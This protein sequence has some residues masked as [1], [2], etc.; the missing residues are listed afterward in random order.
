MNKKLLAIAV[1]AVVAMPA[2]A[3]ADVTVYGR[4]HVSVDM[5]DDGADYNE[6]NMSSNSSRLGF[7]AEKEAGNITGIVQIE[8]QVD[9]DDGAAFVSA[10]DTFVGLKGGLGMVRLGQFD[11]PFKAARGPANLFGDQVGDL[12]NLTRI[13]G[14]S[15][16]IANGFRARFDER[17]PNTIHFQTKDFDGLGFNIAYSI[18]D[19]ATEDKVA[20]EKD[21]ALS[22]SVTYKKDAL[23][24]ALAYETYDEDHNRGERNGARIAA[25]YSLT[26]ELKL[27]GF[28]QTVDYKAGTAV[29]IDALTSDVFGAGAEYKLAKATAVKGMYLS[30]S[31]DADDSDSDMIALGVEHRLDKAIRVYANY[32]VVS[33][34]D[35]VALTPWNQARTTGVAGV[36]GEDA[37]GLSLGLRVDF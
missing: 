18:H 14:G 15:V 28:F 22:V 6:L 29:E 32:A 2:A 3:L 7:K 4:A 5:L 12:R 31:A 26:D 36:A 24:V 13:D 8:Q 17:N 20:D 27:V 30:R 37:S 23:D 9:F 25:A 34:D 35:N 1:G 16:G 19:E 33:N 11:S 10:R 21:E